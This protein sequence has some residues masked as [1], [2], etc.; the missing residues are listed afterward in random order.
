[1]E[2]EFILFP[3]KC[4]RFLASRCRGWRC[5]SHC[6]AWMWERECESVCEEMKGRERERERDTLRERGVGRG[7]V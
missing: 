7:S 5:L 2:Y 1:M 6:T 4:H 3:L